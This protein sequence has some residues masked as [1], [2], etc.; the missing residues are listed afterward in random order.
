MRAGVCICRII[1]LTP[2]GGGGVVRGL[3]RWGK[4]RGG[5]FSPPWKSQSFNCLTHTPGTCKPMLCSKSKRLA[6]PIASESSPQH[7]NESAVPNCPT[8]MDPRDAVPWASSLCCRHPQ[9]SLG[10]NFATFRNF[11]TKFPPPETA[12]PLSRTANDLRTRAA[13]VGA[14]R[15]RAVR[16]FPPPPKKELVQP[17]RQATY[18]SDCGLPKIHP[19]IPTG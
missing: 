9:M 10:E 14:L 3:F 8:S 13:A 19:Q 11:P 4:C 7:P 1:F 18:K 6:N 15:P 2:G 16:T 12:T 17:P 5:K